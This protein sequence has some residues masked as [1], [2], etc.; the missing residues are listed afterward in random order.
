MT[1]KTLAIIKII[2]LLIVIFL[3]SGLLVALLIRQPLIINNTTKLLHSETITKDIKTINIESTSSDIY[4]KKSLSKDISYKIYGQNKQNI[5]I[6]ISNDV[7]KIN[8]RNNYANFQFFSSKDSRIELEVP[9]N[10]IGKLNVKTI[11][12]DIKLL[13]EISLDVTIKS[14]SGDV[15]IYKLQE[16][17]AQTTSGD[18]ELNELSNGTL[19]TTSGDIEIN[20]LTESCNIN[21]LSG[22]VEINTLA[23]TK[24]SKITTTSGSVE[25]KRTIDVYINHKTTSGKFD[26]FNNNRKSS[27]ELLITT[28]SG[29]I[30]VNSYDD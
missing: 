17:I 15:E 12:G 29:D 19:T 7:L 4:I 13:D 3:L 9:E 23:L 21:T 14:T 25:I 6:D 26:I 30:E 24:D 28:T 11:S 10:L 1:N 8:D 27:H 18:L 5:N 16:L 2:L 22:D 20:K